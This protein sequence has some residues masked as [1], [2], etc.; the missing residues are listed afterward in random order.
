[1][2]HELVVI[3]DEKLSGVES[4]VLGHQRLLACGS[5]SSTKLRVEEKSTWKTMGRGTKYDRFGFA[6]G[7]QTTDWS[8]YR[9][10]IE[11][12]DLLCAVF[13]SIR[14]H[15]CAEKFFLLFCPRAVSFFK[16]IWFDCLG[17]LLKMKEWECKQ[18]KR[19]PKTVFSLPWTDF[20]SVLDTVLSETPG[21]CRIQVWY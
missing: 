8:G 7:M 5:S 12:Q 15:C 6:A 3:V 18:K 14:I 19:R 20:V 4:C 2:N 10:R 16:W 1:M 17:A 9:I 13:F 21:T 11:M